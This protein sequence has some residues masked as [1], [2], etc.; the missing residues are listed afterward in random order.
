MFYG[1]P[2]DII[3]E[4]S[5]KDLEINPE[6]DKI[7]IVLTYFLNLFNIEDSITLEI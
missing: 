5:I 6:E 1:N 3:P 4:I 7:Y 2:I